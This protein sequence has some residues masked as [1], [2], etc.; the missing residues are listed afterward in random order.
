MSNKKYN[1]PKIKK[2][3]VC[4]H[5]QSFNQNSIHIYIQNVCQKNNI[6]GIK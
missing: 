1:R 5:K 3:R 6:Y 2:A 4:G